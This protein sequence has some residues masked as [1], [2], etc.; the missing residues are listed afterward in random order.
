MNE[1]QRDLLIHQLSTNQYLEQVNFLK[2][3][4]LTKKKMIFIRI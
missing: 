2:N 1:D 3:N 4:Q